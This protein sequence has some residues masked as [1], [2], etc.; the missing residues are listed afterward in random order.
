MSPLRRY[1]RRVK[2]SL[3]SGAS[4]MVLRRLAAATSSA[5][6]GSAVV[7][8]RGVSLLLWLCVGEVV[9]GSSDAVPAVPALAEVDKSKED[10][11]EDAADRAVGT[12]GDVRDRG[13]TGD[14]EA[15]VEEEGG[16]DDDNTDDDAE[17]AGGPGGGED[18]ED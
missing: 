12:T 6:V 8:V 5:A 1:E 17:T 13:V 18:E 4:V 14:N 7:A 11:E 15:G 2:S 3:G 9:G 16:G 10:A